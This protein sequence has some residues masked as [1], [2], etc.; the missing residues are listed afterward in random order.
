MIGSEPAMDEALDLRSNFEGGWQTLASQPVPLIL[1]ALLTGLL[2]S[3]TFGLLFGPMAVGYCGMCLRAAQGEHVRFGDVFDGFQRIVPTFLLGLIMAVLITIGFIMLW[4]PGLIL[5]VMFFFG[6]WVMALEPEMS[7]ADCLK[8]SI[9]LFKRNVGGT[10]LFV[11]AASILSAS[12]SLVA[13][14][15]IVTGPLAACMV[16]HGA[17]RA[18]AGAA[19]GEEA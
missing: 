3:M 14:G 10:I 4:V 15:S 1:G 2:S 13:F 18:A 5:T 16:A 8:A 12:G 7:P 11:L 19:A 6:P 17:L 9:E